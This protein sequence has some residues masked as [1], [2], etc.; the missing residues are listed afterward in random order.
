MEKEEEE[1]RGDGRAWRRRGRRAA[2]CGR[3]WGSCAGEEQRGSVPAAL[4]G[5]R[6]PPQCHHFLLLAGITVRSHKLFLAGR[7]KRAINTTIL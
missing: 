6:I 5:S 2:Q 4:A 7:A 1:D 3:V